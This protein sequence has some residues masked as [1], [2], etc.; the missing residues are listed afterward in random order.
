MA[1]MKLIYTI[2]SKLDSLEQV[3]GQVI[4]IPA[5]NRIALD[6]KGQRFIYKTIQVFDTDEERINAILATPGFYFVEETGSLWRLTNSETWRLI[7]SAENN[8]I[9]Y[10]ENEENLPSIGAEGTLYYT[11]RGFYNWKSQF[12]NYNLIANANIWESI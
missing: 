6:I 4:F 3:D 8:F 1:L 9:F 2:P 12:N 10:R 7:A 11:D 5:D